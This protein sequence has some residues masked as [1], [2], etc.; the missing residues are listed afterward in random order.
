MGTFGVVGVILGPALT[1]RA[2]FIEIR[3]VKRARRELEEARTRFQQELEAYALRTRDLEGQL[4][5]TEPVEAMIAE[6]PGS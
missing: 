4:D 5:R 2:I 6:G 3:R 1:V